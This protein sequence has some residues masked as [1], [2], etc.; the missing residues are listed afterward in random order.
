MRKLFFIL[1]LSCTLSLYAQSDNY[2]DEYNQFRDKAQ[3]T[4]A[5]QKEK[6]AEDYNTFRQKVNETYA[7]FLEQAWQRFQ[8]QPPI[9]NPENDIPVVPPLEPFDTIPFDTIPNQ[10]PFDKIIPIP[11]YPK[12]PQPIVPIYEEP[13]PQQEPMIEFTFYGT[14]CQVRIATDIKIKL[15]TTDEATLGQL[16]RECNQMS[17]NNLIRDCL[18]LRYKLSLCDYAYLQMLNALA[19]QYYGVDSDEAVFLMAYLYCQSGYKMR[20]GRS[21]DNRLVMFFFSQHT[22]FNTSYFLIDEAKAY[23][24]NFT[25]KDCFISSVIFE[26]EQPLS[27]Q[28]SSAPQFDNSPASQRVIS[29]LRYPQISMSLSVNKNL[30]DFYDR[31]PYSEFS[32]DFMTQWAIYANTPLGKEVKQSLYQPLK[33]YIEGMSQKEAVSR[34]LNWVQTGFEYK[35]DKEAWGEERPFFPDETL[36]YPYCDCEDRSILFTRMVRDLLGLD[37]LLVYYPGHLAAAV[38]FTQPVSGDYILCE[39]NKYIICD[40]TYIGADVGRTMPQ[41]NNSTATIIK[42]K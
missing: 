18:E 14:K 31:Y 34:L 3:A 2:V 21:C 32:N 11:D 20:L 16:W 5:S 23:P 38:N 39:G 30:I 7:T 13:Q 26:N 36:Y 41:M 22:I 27:L 29:S 10:F 19:S 28:L 4:F 33:S 35:T 25:D 8:S 15:P 40:P 1:A 6:N 37:A 24:Y 9:P 17:F 42:L 12:Q